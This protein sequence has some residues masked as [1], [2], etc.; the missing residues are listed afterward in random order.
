MKTRP[1]AFS[2]NS[3]LTAAR[4]VD[5]ASDVAPDDTQWIH[6]FPAGKNYGRD[7]RGPYDLR[8]AAT[9]LARTQE[10]HGRTR[11]VVD[12]EH[13]TRNALKNGQPAPAAGWIVGLESR[14][15]GIWA[16]V[17]WTAAAAKAVREKAYRYVSPVFFHTRD[18]GEVLAVQNVALTNTPNLDLTALASVEFSMDYEQEL[19]KLRA[20]L[21]LADDADMQ[22]I[23]A[24][25]TDLQQV[26]AASAMPD[27]AQYVPIG[28][29]TRVVKDAN[30]LRQGVT[31]DA[32]TAHVAEQ[33]R[34]GRLAPMSREWAISLCTTNKPAFDA[35]MEEV[36]PAFNSMLK[37]SGLG[38]RQPGGLHAGNSLTAS[39][40]AVCSTMGLTEEEFIKS[41]GRD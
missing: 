32:A 34:T 12:Y 39:E 37:P 31:K 13:Q 21:G 23:I 18:T 25:V 9:V 40:L 6:I 22:A 10:Y 15:D 8:D 27:P 38:A 36:G 11:M 29:Y 7:G 2:A 19:A 28:E 5:L 35:F 14:A 3:A 33:I 16:K 4:S 17:E 30:S 24:A 41:R 20:L 26:S 1:A